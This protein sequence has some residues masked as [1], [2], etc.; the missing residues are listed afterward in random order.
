MSSNNRSNYHMFKKYNLTIIKTLIL[1]TRF[2]INYKVNECKKLL[3]N[4]PKNLIFI[5]NIKKIKINKFY[6]VIY[7]NKII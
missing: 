5:R 3:Q 6:Q 2:I 1:I 4:A 7:Q